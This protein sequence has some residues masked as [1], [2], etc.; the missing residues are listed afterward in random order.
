MSRRYDVEIRISGRTAAV[1]AAILL[2]AAAFAT[3]TAARAADGA[4]GS[5]SDPVVTKSYVD[6][7]T[8][9]AGGTFVPVEVEAGGVIIG[10]AGAEII[11]RSGAGTVVCPGIDGISDLTGGSDLTAGDRASANHLLL[12][13]RDDGRGVAATTN[14][15]VMVRGPYTVNAN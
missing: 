7:R 12:V 11:V 2:F 5:E 4:P 3:V 9:E 13:P 1:C 14:L 6:K 10:G 8:A 15:W